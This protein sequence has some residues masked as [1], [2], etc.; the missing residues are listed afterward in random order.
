MS[1]GNTE[2]FGNR[3]KRLRQIQGISQ[4]KLADLAD[5]DRTY[6]HGIESGKRNVSIAVISKIAKAFQITM[7]ELLK[8]L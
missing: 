4:E 1:Y 3:V 8:E 2:N 6:I 7:S 5:L